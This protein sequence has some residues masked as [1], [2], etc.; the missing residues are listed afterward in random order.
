MQHDDVDQ[1]MPLDDACL[2]V[3][4]HDSGHAAETDSV[5]AVDDSRRKLLKRTKA[6]LPVVLTLTVSNGLCVS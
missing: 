2:S 6:A 5:S 3:R 1:A 4:P